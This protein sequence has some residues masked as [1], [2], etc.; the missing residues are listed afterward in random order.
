MARLI[1][2]ADETETTVTLVLEVS[3]KDLR[4]YPQYY[5]DYKPAD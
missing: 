1:E 4:N 5:G 2:V 3:K